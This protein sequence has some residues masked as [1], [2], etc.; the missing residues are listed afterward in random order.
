MRFTRLV[1]P[2]LPPN[3]A[4]RWMCRLTLNDTAAYVYASGP[5]PEAA[6][7][8]AAEQVAAKI[9]EVLL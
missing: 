2:R 9:E 8:L 1:R 4:N 7:P 6:L 5:S 3:E